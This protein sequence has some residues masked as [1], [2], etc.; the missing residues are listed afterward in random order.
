MTVHIVDHSPRNPPR[1]TPSDE[2]HLGLVGY[3]LG[4]SL[5]PA[6]HQ[7]ALRSLG[8][9]G[10]YRLYP[11]FPLPEGWPSLEGLLKRV[12]SCELDGLNVTIPHKL[13]VIPFLDR[14]SPAARSIGAVNTIVL[15]G[16][17]LTGENTDA[18]GFMVDFSHHLAL[19][20][21]SDRGK[22]SG[23]RAMVLGSGGAARAVTYALLQAGWQV[24]ILARNPR[25]GQVLMQDLSA[26]ST[27]D[28]LALLPYN[29]QGISDGLAAQ[30]L[31][32]IVNATPLGM[33]PHVDQSPWPAV[34]PFPPGALVYDLVYNPSVTQFTR[35][36]SQAGLHACTGIGMLVEQAVLSFQAWTGL[37]PDRQAMLQAAQVS[38]V[39]NTHESG[40]DD[41]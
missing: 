14:L 7:A 26:R 15:R 34:I 5:S 17:V 20:G 12:R 41:D 4:H 18:A 30:P 31:N 3:P 21:I 35:S 2:I 1:L 8:L 33:V 40:G 6:L 36:A 13:A 29:W 23:L 37:V 25:Q 16:S 10:S 24:V 19:A 28:R 9:R 32:A 39:G 11:V 22:T 27:D 38:L